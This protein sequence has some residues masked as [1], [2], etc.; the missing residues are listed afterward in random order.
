MESS[1][2]KTI[3][4][5]G[6]SGFLGQELVKQLLDAETFKVIAATSR[7]G[8]FDEVLNAING[9][10]VVDTNN[11]KG[12]LAPDTKI[13]VLVNCAF[14]RTSDP[15]TLAKGIIYTEKLIK[16]A[17]DFDIKS[18]I[19]ISS[20][21]VYSQKAKDLV[22]EKSPV[23]PESHYGMTKFAC[24]R[25]VASL[26]DSGN[27][28]Y[29]NIRLGSLTGVD[30]D[31]RMPNRFVQSVFNGDPIVI[32]GGNQKISYLE[33]RDAASA[34]IRMVKEDPNKWNK[35]YNL[36]QNKYFTVIE[37]AKTVERKATK[38]ISNK[39][40]LEIIDGESNFSNIVNSNLFYNDFRWNPEIEMSEMVKDLFTYYSNANKKN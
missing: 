38:Y 32:N 18:I 35:T 28:L 40:N 22:N 4:V 7:K 6:A 34:L 10:Q 24:E 39:V 33:V 21:S 31:V 12:E 20:Q 2:L 19:N 15:G 13:D 11:W 17:I 14:P 5:T 36:G 27:T 16:D 30:L 23:M 8:T 3:L 1:D 37:L 25:I 9:F 29:S 26:C